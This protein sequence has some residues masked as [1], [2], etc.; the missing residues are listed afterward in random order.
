ME[1]MNVFQFKKLNGDNY[2][3][4]KLDIRMLLMER[5]LF[6]FI[7]KSEPV[8]AEGATSREKM[9]FECQK[10]KALATIYFSLEESQKDLVAE[11]GIAKEV[12][13]LLEEIS[14]QKSRTRTA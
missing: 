9:E 1:A 3:Q 5:G 6:K 14:E 13:T 7:D 8:L 10:C 11:A 2:R 4:W 12:W